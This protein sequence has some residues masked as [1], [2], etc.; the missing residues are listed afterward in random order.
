MCTKQLC[1]APENIICSPYK[2][3]VHTIYMFVRQI[4]IMCGTYEYNVCTEYHRC[5]PSYCHHFASVVVNLL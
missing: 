4:N 5:R 2:Y 3:N 1:T